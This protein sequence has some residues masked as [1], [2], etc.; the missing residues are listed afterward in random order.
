MATWLAT[1]SSRPGVAEEAPRSVPIIDTHQHLWDLGRVQ[2]PW[3]PLVPHLNRNYLPKD[4][5][6]AAEG[7][8]IVKTVYME[9]NAAEQSQQAEA[10][11]VLDICRRGDT[12][13]T[14][15]VIGGCPAADHF[16]SYILQFKDSP[17]VKGIRQI[18]RKGE[19]YADVKFR[20]GIQFLGERG[21]C[22]DLC[23]GPDY[24]REA[25]GLIDACPGTRFVLDHCGNADVKSFLPPGKDE[26]AARV[27]QRRQQAQQWRLGMAAMAQR[28]N[29]VCKIS[30]IIASAPK[31]AWAP[32][33]LAPIVRHCLEVFGPDRVMFAG[34]WPVCTA[35]ATLREWVGA[36]KQIVADPV[37][38]RKLFHDNA[39]RFYALR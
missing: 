17:Y 13:M 25:A 19:L 3:V 22:F 23:Q 29:V 36:L 39:A 6:Q 33:Q 26:P 31:G 35:V 10:D 4:Y 34:D 30:G 15:A 7:L 1:S 28:K 2:L 9:V 18:L 16:R 38:Q 5:A 21:L 14:A 24:L 27:A 11:Y 8:G 37:Q 32:E 20:R 12:P